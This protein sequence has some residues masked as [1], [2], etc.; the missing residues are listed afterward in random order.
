MRKY[1]LALFT[2]LA[3]LPAITPAA[4][5][6]STHGN[7]HHTEPMGPMETMDHSEHMENMNHSEH[8]ESMGEMNHPEHMEGMNHDEHLEHSPKANPDCSHH[9]INEPTSSMSNTDLVVHAGHEH[10]RRKTPPANN[11]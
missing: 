6:Q 1:I 8:M 7:M 11:G 10:G 5:A 3:I 9:T 4:I 2:S